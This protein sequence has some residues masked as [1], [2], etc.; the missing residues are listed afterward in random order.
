MKFYQIPLEVL[1]FLDQQFRDF[2]PLIIVKKQ[3]REN[4]EFVRIVWEHFD[5]RNEFDAQ[6]F[7]EYYTGSRYMVEKEY[8]GLHIFE[9]ILKGGA[10]SLKKASMDL[11]ML[12]N[13]K[14]LV[15]RRLTMS[16]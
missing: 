16:Q 4:L 6:G 13:G 5:I 3:D 2:L 1:T 15:T 14:Y 12:E 9:E 10:H 11:V 7:I 8:Y